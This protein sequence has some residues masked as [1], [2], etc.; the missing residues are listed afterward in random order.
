MFHRTHGVN[1]L[2][3]RIRN[4]GKSLS[5]DESENAVGYHYTKRKLIIPGVRQERETKGDRA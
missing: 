5:K 2:N 1:N 3:T 4:D